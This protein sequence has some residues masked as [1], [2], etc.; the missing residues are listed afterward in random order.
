MAICYDLV[1]I[2]SWNLLITVCSSSL[3]CIKV[4]FHLHWKFNANA[5][6]IHQVTFNLDWE[7]FHSVFLSNEQ[8]HLE[9]INNKFNFRTIMWPK[10]CSKALNKFSHIHCALGNFSEGRRYPRQTF[11]RRGRGGG[12]ECFLKKFVNLNDRLSFTNILNN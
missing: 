3:L 5:I 12:S 2:A 10:G 7:T 11:R 6:L 4:W 1:G 8:L 9:S